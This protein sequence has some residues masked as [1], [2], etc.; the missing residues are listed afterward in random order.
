MVLG[1]F[2]SILLINELSNLLFF[3]TGSS[4]VP[5]GGFK[6]LDSNNGKICRFLISHAPYIKNSKNYIKSHT[7]FNTIDLP[8]YE[9]KEELEEAIRFVSKNQIWDF[10]M[11]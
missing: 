5:L 2:I 4:R 8:C 10:G 1:N 3:A 11:E 7:C 9:S 6:E